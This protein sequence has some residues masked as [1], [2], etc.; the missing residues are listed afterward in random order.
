MIFIKFVI[1]GFVSLNRSHKP[2]HMASMASL[3]KIYCTKPFGRNLHVFG[4]LFL[5]CRVTHNILLYI[6]TFSSAIPFSW[7]P[8]WWHWLL[9]GTQHCP[10]AGLWGRWT[11]GISTS[12]KPT[13][14]A[15]IHAGSRAL[16]RYINNRQTLQGNYTPRFWG[17]KPGKTQFDNRDR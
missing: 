13:G 2:Y 1:K 11:G 15:H 8:H 12:W 9:W 17:S 14:P 3:V 16:Q 4:F 6:V 5:F 10:T 7:A